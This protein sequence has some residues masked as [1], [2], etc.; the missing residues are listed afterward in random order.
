ML[1]DVGPPTAMGFWGTGSAV[2]PSGPR[3]DTSLGVPTSPAFSFLEA[4]TF[5]I[6]GLPPP[7]EASSAPPTL[8][9]ERATA[10]TDP[11]YPRPFFQVP[12]TVLGT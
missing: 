6:L 2:T 7:G 11:G 8:S 5:R 12:G 10:G 1:G 4:F 3:E 9:Q